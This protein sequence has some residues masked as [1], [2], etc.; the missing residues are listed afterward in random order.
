MPCRILVRTRNREILII[1]MLLLLVRL[2]LLSHL[3]NHQFRATLCLMNHVSHLLRTAS[4]SASSLSVR[5]APARRLPPLQCIWFLRRLRE[6]GYNANRM[7][8]QGVSLAVYIG[9][10][11][12]RD[13]HVV[14]PS[15]RGRRAV[16]Q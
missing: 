9:K 11:Q 8:G 3:A 12:L 14:C 7:P 16:L 5:G 10:L 13:L 1:A 2:R 4:R 6:R 15:A